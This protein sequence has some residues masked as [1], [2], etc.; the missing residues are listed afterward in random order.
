MISHSKPTLGEEEEKAVI[1]VLRSGQIAEG[2]IVA[3]F[4]RELSEYI[5][6]KGGVATNSGHS[7]LHLALIALGISSADEVITS[8]YSS[9]AL[10]N[11]VGYTGAKTVLV[12]INEY[13]FNVSS[14]DVRRKVTPRTKA[15]IVPH[16]FGF[17]VDMDALL[18][19]S[20]PIIEDCA[21][22]IGAS[23]GGKMVGSFG[24]LAMYSF[25]ATKMLTA[26]DGGMVTTNSSE[27]LDEMRDIKDC[28]GKTGYRLRYKYK[29]TDIQAAIGV[30]QLAKLPGFIER[31]REIA[32]LYSQ[33]L[34]AL[35][36]ELP[37][38]RENTVSTYYRYVI[39]IKKDL[40][41]FKE[42]MRE[43]GIICGN[44][45]MEPLH[46]AIGLNNKDFPNCER[47]FKSAVSL[48]IYPF[49]TNKEVELISDNVG[50]IL[51]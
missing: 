35:N 34:S 21:Q 28:L 2:A 30:C 37:E 42:K 16:M 43:K 27:Y 36:V 23:I 20:I 8:T 9:P 4:E 1:E 14:S 19:L 50:S 32:E 12:D 17:P 33:C 31:R 7:A 51:S 10:L 49:L 13:D 38:T 18:E 11:A 46:R 6:V 22:S 15:I 40:V 24:E 3:R 25:Y 45:V 26:A 44:G 48:P 39:L 29:M 5:G 47:V 41:K